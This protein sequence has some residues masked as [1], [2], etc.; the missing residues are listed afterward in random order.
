M[1]NLPTFDSSNNMVDH[2]FTLGTIGNMRKKLTPP[3]YGSHSRVT[4]RARLSSSN[5]EL[6]SNNIFVVGM[7]LFINE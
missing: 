5:K 7:G 2:L 1:S 4:C 6:M 3:F